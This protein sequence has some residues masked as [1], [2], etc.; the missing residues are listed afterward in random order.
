[1]TDLITNT[2]GTALGALLCAGSVKHNWFARAG[3]SSVLPFG[4]EEKVFSS[5]SS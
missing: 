5:L 2:S 4:K 1:M 3:V